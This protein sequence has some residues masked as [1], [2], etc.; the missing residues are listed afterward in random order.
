MQA[1]L[2]AIM[3]SFLLTHVPSDIA[4]VQQEFSIDPVTRSMPSPEDV[5]T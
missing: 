2:D 1:T 4:Y 5:I 3:A